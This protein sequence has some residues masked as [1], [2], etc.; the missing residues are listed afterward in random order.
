MIAFGAPGDS[1]PS[2]RVG[3]NGAG[4]GVSGSF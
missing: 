4:L 2:A 1:E 3:L